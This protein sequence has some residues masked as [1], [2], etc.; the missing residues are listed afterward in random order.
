[1]IVPQCIKQKT[2]RNWQ[3]N[4]MLLN[5]YVNSQQAKDN[6]IFFIFADFSWNIH[7]TTIKTTKTTTTTTGPFYFRH[8]ISATCSSKSHRFSVSLPESFNCNFLFRFFLLLLKVAIPFLF[9]FLRQ[10]FERVNSNSLSKFILTYLIGHNN[11]FNG[12]WPAATHTSRRL[13]SLRAYV[14]WLH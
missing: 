11:P 10:C 14:S 5:V 8:F 9:F 13:C 7:A 4:I 3:R 2:I 12:F 6:K 1:M